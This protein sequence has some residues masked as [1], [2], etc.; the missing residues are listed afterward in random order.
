MAATWLLTHSETAQFLILFP[1][2]YLPTAF[3]RRRV[4]GPDEHAEV[5]AG[6]LPPWRLLILS[7]LLVAPAGIA[8][9]VLSRLVELGL[10]WFIALMWAWGEIYATLIRR[11]IEHRGT[12]TWR[13][14]RPLRDAASVGL[15]TVPILAAL[16]LLFD[17]SMPLPEAILTGVAC[18]VI[19]GLLGL[20]S[21]WHDRR[22]R[23]RR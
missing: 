3:L 13:A 12:A 7:L 20:F 16:A 22:S 19:V 14:E 6:L 4:E 10:F 8:I 9:D 17:S 2:I 23:P 11:E 21:N 18:G 1:S 5:A 15:L